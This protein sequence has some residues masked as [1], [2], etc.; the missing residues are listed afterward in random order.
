MSVETMS[1]RISTIEQT[2]KDATQVGREGYVEELS[3]ISTGL[4]SV[5]GP[6]AERAEWLTRRLNRVVRN[7]DA[8][9]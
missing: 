7:I 9:K 3:E 8:A 4:G 6:E 1:R 2:W 5:T